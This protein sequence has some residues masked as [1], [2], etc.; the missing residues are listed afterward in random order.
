MTTGDIVKRSSLDSENDTDPDGETSNSDDEFDSTDEDETNI[1]NIN[2]VPNFSGD[3]SN[4]P[5]TDNEM[6]KRSN[7]YY[8]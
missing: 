6:S 3:S 5:A 4:G 8:S 7:F 2:S 1:T